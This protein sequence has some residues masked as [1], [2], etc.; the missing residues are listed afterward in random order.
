[1]DVPKE[2]GYIVEKYLKIIKINLTTGEFKVCIKW[3]DIAVPDVNTLNEWVDDFIK[4][5]MVHP[6]DVDKFKNFINLDNWRKWVSSTDKGL[7]CSYRRKNLEGEHIH[8]SICII[9]DKEQYS[10]QNECAIIFVKDIDSIYKTE[11]ECILED[12]G[13]KDSFTNLLNRFAYQRDVEKYKVGSVGVL[14]ADLNGLKFVNDTYGHAAGDKLILQ[15]ANLLKR[16]FSDYKIYHI[17]GDEFVVI[18]YD[19]NVRSFLQRVLG[20]HRWLWEQG[21]YPM[22]AIGYTLDV[23]SEDIAGLVT[24]AENA[25]YV[26]KDIFYSRYPQYK[27]K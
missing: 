19:T 8:V 26:D 4:Q 21:E 16:A 6:E 25:M 23:N 2:L 27:R 7:Y 13:T 12:I 24:E 3:E 18:A 20:W 22:A 17:S 15:F 14:F 11:Y 10:H 1:M 9:R 5:G